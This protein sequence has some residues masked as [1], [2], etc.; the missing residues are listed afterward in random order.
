MAEAG[1][2]THSGFKPVCEGVHL[3]LMFAVGAYHAPGSSTLATL[4]Y[5]HVKKKSIHFCSQGPYI[6]WEDTENEPKKIV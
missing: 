1:P 2:K 5:I 6:S 4:G 3:F